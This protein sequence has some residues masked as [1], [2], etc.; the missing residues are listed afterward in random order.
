MYTLVDEFYRLTM[1]K[2]FSYPEVD[3][4]EEYTSDSSGPRRLVTSAPPEMT[5]ADKSLH[6]T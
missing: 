6:L 5:V 3:V 1:E 4:D 2:D